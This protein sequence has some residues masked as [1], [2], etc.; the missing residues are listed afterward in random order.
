LKELDPEYFEVDIHNH[1]RLL[2]AIDVIWQTNKKYSEQ[3][4]VSQ[5][6]RDFK[7]VRSE[8]KRREKSCMTELTGEWI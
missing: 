3:I 1:R 8:L 6:S 5:D 2:R 7:T 4:A